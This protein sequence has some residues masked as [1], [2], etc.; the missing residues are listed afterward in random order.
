MLQAVGNQFS[1]LTSGLNFTSIENSLSQI[2]SVISESCQEVLKGQYS[3]QNFAIAGAI[4]FP[5]G[6]CAVRLGIE[7]G[8]TRTFSRKALFWATLTAVSALV[9]CYFFSPQN[10]LSQIPL[11]IVI[12]YP[13]AFLSACGNGIVSG[14]NARANFL[15]RSIADDNADLKKEISEISLGDKMTELLE[16]DRILKDCIC[17]VGYKIITDPVTDGTD[18]YEREAIEACIDQDGLSPLTRTPLEKD[19]LIPLPHLKSLIESR[20]TYYKKLIEANL[21]HRSEEELTQQVDSE[22]KKSC[23]KALAQL[24]LN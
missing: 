20:L 22:L 16:N 21:E 18:I 14:L 15:A 8:F 23:P 9:N 17:P 5:F 1:E 12:G 2:A 7:L 19:K 3:I 6:I 13:F 10:S 11:Q 24:A 4:S